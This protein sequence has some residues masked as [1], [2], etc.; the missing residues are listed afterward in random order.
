ME[1]KR[2]ELLGGA[3]A[4][5]R[6]RRGKENGWER[7]NGKKESYGGEDSVNAVSGREFEDINT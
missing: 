5:E 2:N 7:D 4:K 3:I 6:E 1:E